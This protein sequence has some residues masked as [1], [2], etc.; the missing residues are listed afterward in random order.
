MRL[1]SV[2]QIHV[3]SHVGFFIFI[4]KTTRESFFRFYNNSGPVSEKKEGEN[5]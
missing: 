1:V 4:S 3:F 5:R 2:N